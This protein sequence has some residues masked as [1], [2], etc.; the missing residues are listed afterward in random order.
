M[1]ASPQSAA[2]QG[3]S[4]W[5]APADKP[6]EQ[7]TEGASCIP[8]RA[9]KTLSSSENP[10]ASHTTI[11]KSAPSPPRAVP[12]RPRGRS[13]GV[14]PAAN[15]LG[16]VD[17]DARSLRHS[18]A[19]LSCSPLSYGRVVSGRLGQHVYRAVSESFVSQTRSLLGESAHYDHRC[20]IADHNVLQCGEPVHFRHLE[21]KGDH[22][23]LIFANQPECLHSVV[24][25]SGKL[26][27]GIFSENSLERPANKRRIVDNEHAAS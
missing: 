18:V 21:V 14:G 17:S 23:W 19:Q 1:M 7:T 4:A 13:R 26:Y 11:R 12:V 15:V 27:S 8:E 25:D 9:K 16:G 3:T 24:G 2:R 22:V 20:R 6:V 5:T 10:P